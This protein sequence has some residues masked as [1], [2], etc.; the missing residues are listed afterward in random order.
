MTDDSNVIAQIM[1][2]LTREVVWPHA[3]KIMKEHGWGLPLWIKLETRVGS[4]FKT[5]HRIRYVD[6]L[7]SKHIITYGVKAVRDQRDFRRSNNYRTGF[8]IKEK[9]YFN[10]ELRHSNVIAHLILHETAHAIQTFLGYRYDNEMHNKYFYYFLDELSRACDQ[11]VHDELVNRAQQ[12]SVSM[13][14]DLGTY[15]ID[16]DGNLSLNQPKL[17]ANAI[18]SYTARDGSRSL[19]VILDVGPK[20]SEA[21][22]YHGEGAGFRYN[23]ANA[24]IGHIDPEDP[25]PDP[26]RDIVQRLDWSVGDFCH[27]YIDGVYRG[28]QIVKVNKKTC[29]VKVLE[30]NKDKLGN[31]LGEEFTVSRFILRRDLLVFPIFQI[32]RD[33]VFASR[34][35]QKL[36]A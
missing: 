9:G 30:G 33:K 4:G 5:C 15:V 1:C 18:V 12:Q 14:F 11:E 32:F 3:K 29:L 20:K 19:G 25:L 13:G 23:L 22:I 26:K 16:G 21:Y 10:G 27:Y 17:E 6:N 2:D 31:K 35:E 36:A 8:E 7:Y 28:A 34:N 24:L